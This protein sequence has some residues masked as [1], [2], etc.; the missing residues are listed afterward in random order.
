MGSQGPEGQGWRSRAGAAMVSSA[1]SE[2]DR[3]SPITGQTQQHPDW[4]W[5]ILKPT[6]A[7]RSLGRRYCSRESD[8]R[9]GLLVASAPSPRQEHASVTQP[10]RAG[11]L[12]GRVEGRRCVHWAV[13][14]SMTH[15][16]PLQAWQQS[17]EPFSAGIESYDGEVFPPRVRNSE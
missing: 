1:R 8:L 6:T 4:H 12:D 7:E 16:C 3:G 11:S 14:T 13:G 17:E 2:M 10:Q 5:Q 15:M 9:L